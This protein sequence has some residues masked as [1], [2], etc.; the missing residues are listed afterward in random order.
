MNLYLVR[1]TRTALAPG[2]CYGRLDVALGPEAH[3]DMARTLA[4]IPPVTT[5]WTSPLK[6]CLRLAQRLAAREGIR[7]VVDDRLVELSFGQWEG[8]R[9][10]EL[11]RAQTEQW[12]S[13][14]WH[15]APPGGETTAQ[16]HARVLQV[17]EDIESSRHAAVAIIS[18]GG[19]IRLAVCACLGT[20]IPARRFTDITIGFGQVLRL[21]KKQAHWVCTRLKR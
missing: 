3:A 14:H 12:A 16:L 2:I 18:H 20:G 17:L 10:D 15:T 7:P 8:K 21:T 1:H 13:G 11:G 6:R 4:L 5:I 19:P 9:W